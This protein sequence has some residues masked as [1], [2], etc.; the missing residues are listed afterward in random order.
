VTSLLN[1]H[2][3]IDDMGLDEDYRPIWNT[4]MKSPCIDN[5]NPDT[6]GDGETW[7]TDHGDRDADGTQMD[8][9][10]IPLLDGHIHRV[11]RL[12]ND[13]VRYISIPGVV[14]YTE[15]GEQNSLLYVFDEFRSNGLF[16]TLPPVLEQIKWRY[17]DDD[18]YA[19]PY[20]IPEHYVHSQNGYKVT[21]TEDAEDMLIQYHGYYP[22]NTMNQ[23]MFIQDLDRYTTDHYILPP[24][25]DSPEDS[26]TGIP[27]RE[28]YLG[29]YLS[30]S[31]K[32]FDALNPILDNITAIFAEDWAWV[33]LPSFGYIP[34]PGAEPSDAYTDNWLGCRPAGSDEITIN[35]GEMVVIRYIG[36]DPSEFKLGGDNPDPPFTDP[37][38]REMASHFGYEEQPEYVPIF[39]SIDLNQFEDG[40]KP[41]EVA[42]FVDEEC[43]GAAVILDEEVQLN[44]YVTN[45]TDPSEELKNLEFRMFFPGKAANA[46]VLDYSVLN[47][48]SGR[49]ESRKIAVS[50]CKEFLQIRIGKTE[51]TPVPSITQ[52]FNN[53]PNPFNPETTIRFDLA[54][55]G[56]V[57]IDVFNIKGQKM[58]ALVNDS[59]IAGQHSIIWDGTDSKGKPVV[60]GVYFYRMTTPKSTLVHKMLLMK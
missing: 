36:Q 57:T 19:S 26:N 14:N 8:I 31:L 6:N 41:V 49:F 39:L 12:T 53:Y 55:P 59:F 11:H 21:L 42:V 24:D 34:V 51:E 17:N 50:E 35:P 13:K 10:A 56:P 27:Y 25:A 5:G 3:N 43:K 40:N 58:Q 9:G 38:F 18:N 30:E 46:N 52:L 48:Q 45:I 23:G 47:N 7:L 44:A 15:S 37:H 33:R 22:G 1:S 60:S 2:Y 16:T 20:R 54:E 32:P 29:Y 4:T 28:I